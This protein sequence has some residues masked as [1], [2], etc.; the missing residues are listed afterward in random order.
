MQIEAGRTLSHYELIEKIGQGGM[1]V[2]WKARD[3]I[4]GREV[5]IKVLP[6]DLAVDAQRRRMFLEEARL[7]SSVSDA[8]IVQVFELGREGDLD[9]IVM[10][11]VEGEPLSKSLT[12]RPL[13]ADRV[14]ALGEQVARAL[15][16]AHRKQL[17]HRDI[18]PGNILVTPDGEAKLVDFGLAGL[19]QPEGQEANPW[20]STRPLDETTGSWVE[21]GGHRVF[22]T[23]PYMSPEQVRGEKLD[24]RSDIFSLG[25]V[26]YE[27]TLGQRPFRGDSREMLAAE[28]QKGCSEP[29][30]E[31]L[32][33]LPA[34]LDRIV[35][36]SLAARPAQRYQSMEE[37]AIDLRTLSR[38]L[39]SGSAPSYGELQK[40]AALRTRKRAV[41]WAAALLVA[42]TV[43]GAAWMARD[44]WPTAV[45]PRT[46]LILPLEV[47]GQA[48]GAS[49]VGRAFAEA[50]AVNL[51]Q[52]EGLK[53]LPVPSE[54]ESSGIGALNRAREARA[55][56]AGLVLAGSLTRQQGAV[57]ADINLMDAREDRLIWGTRLPGDEKELAELAGTA[58][59]QVES[60]LELRRK[61]RYDLFRVPFGSEEFLTSEDL[62][63]AMRIDEQSREYL[64]ATRRLIERFPTET[65]ARLLN[66]LA[67]Y[68]ECRRHGISGSARLEFDESIRALD[69]MDPNNPW[70]DFFRAKLAEV[71]FDNR[72]AIGR[73]N[74][75]LA[76]N[77]LTTP[78][79]SEA[80]YVRGRAFSS[81]GRLNQALRDFNEMLQLAPLD[82]GSLGETGLTHIALGNFDAGLDL[83]RKAFAVEPNDPEALAFLGVALWNAGRVQD[84]LPYLEKQCRMIRTA[85]EDENACCF[86]YSLA[87]AQ[88]GQVEASLPLLERCC[89]E[90]VERC[91][92]YALSL[93]LDGQSR[94]AE[95]QA[96]KSAG[97]D[98]GVNSLYYLAAYHAVAG[99]RDKAIG[100]L[101]L[102]VER[103]YVDCWLWMD[104]WLESLHGDP[105]FEAIVAEIRKRIES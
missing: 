77:D 39:Q 68:V 38:D 21:W 75:V 52:A 99:H 8:H 78:M 54:R 31:H 59:Q 72:E 14:A 43:A 82:V 5:A 10:E 64:A 71:F 11:Y 74:N 2:V 28:I 30:R 56:K 16:R 40:A 89:E 22:G 88:S 26:L 41:K 12:G 94:E 105:G 70:S 19:F 67:L 33:Q 20:V 50:M 48:A 49:Y 55:L 92:M 32:P 83:A 4:L 91:S 42:G 93:E 103:G 86:Y 80:V 23:L 84:G 7:A 15:A 9:F 96:R 66:V 18:K 100:I 101:R 87:L 85:A 58:V 60:K 6:A 57:V 90:T 69:R 25:T 65:Y 53:V 102:L 1:G 104:P 81:S 47:R 3:S 51:A 17:L 95:L 45:D 24:Q 97:S 35:T 61:R 27:M 37:L 44:R 73:I 34:D 46:M 13:P 79:R 62:T 63:A 98:Q 76:R 36:K 29:L